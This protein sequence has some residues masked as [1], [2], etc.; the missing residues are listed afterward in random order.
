MICVYSTLL[1][2][3]LTHSRRERIARA[4]QAL[5]D[6]AKHSLGPRPCRR[7]QYE[8]RKQIDEIL[9]RLHVKRYIEAHFKRVA[10]HIFKQVRR[11]RPGPDTQFTRK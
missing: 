3:K 11:G 5:A 1:R 7:S 9:E 2:L 4:K 10:Q 6:L 8:I